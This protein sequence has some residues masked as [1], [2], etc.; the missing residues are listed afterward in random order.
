MSALASA[1][2][3]TAAP[4]RSPGT[5][6]LVGLMGAG[7]TAIGRRLSAELGLPFFDAD[8]EIESAAG[9]SIEEFFERYG[10]PAFRE[11]ERKVMARLLSG[12]ACVIA[13]G[14]G[15]FMDSETRALI[16]EKSTS[17]WLRADLDVLVKR[18]A[19]RGNR[20]L[21]KKEDPATVLARLIAERYPVYAEAD[22]TVDSRAD[23]PEETLADVL[24]Q[25]RERMTKR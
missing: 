8:T 6:V 21:L 20:P 25:L 4:A 10:E 17:V 13:S 18:T 23:A 24:A 1:T 3:S 5:I 7:K 22:I 12:S 16:R 2:E 14:G 9:C 15:A 19:R 11:G